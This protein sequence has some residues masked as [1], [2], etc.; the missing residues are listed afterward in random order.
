M[1][2]A[3]SSRN[4]ASQIITPSLK[5]LT[6]SIEEA[7]HALGIKR[8]AVYTEIS[9]GRLRVIRIGHELRVPRLE[10]HAYI[11]RMLEGQQL[12]PRIGNAGRSSKPDQLLLHAALN[13]IQCAAMLALVIIFALELLSVQPLEILCGIVLAYARKML[14]NSRLRNKRSRLNGNQQRPD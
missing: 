2:V 5:A 4:A 10:L 13:T 3:A 11:S 7:A 8:G 1:S 6:L 12:T 9:A 14:R